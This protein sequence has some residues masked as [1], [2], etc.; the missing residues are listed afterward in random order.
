MNGTSSADTNKN[1]QFQQPQI[2]TPQK[3]TQQVTTPSATN[4]A[5]PVINSDN[6]YERQY[7]C[8]R[9]GFFTNNPRAVLYHRKE[10]HFEKIN[11]HECS[12][13]QYASQYSGK[14]ERH[15]LL[16]HKI[17]IN[18]SPTKKLM[19]SKLKSD[20]ASTNSTNQTSSALDITLNM[21]TIGDE[22]KQ[23]LNIAKF[24]CN[25]CP[26]KYKRS[27]DLYKH[28]KL[29]HGILAQRL[30]DY[31]TQENSDDLKNQQEDDQD[32]NEDI[33]NETN[34][35]DENKQINE[36]KINSYECPYCTYYS[37]GNDAEYLLHVKDHLCGKSF[38]C[39]L[40]NSVY[41]YRGDCVVHLK[42]K[43]QKS[44]LYAQN[45]VERFNLDAIDISQV[46]V[47]LKPKQQIQLQHQ[48][49]LQ[50]NK[51]QH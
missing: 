4:L 44:D 31:L 11:V 1:Q 21:S 16:R 2:P 7:T 25:K 23:D 47:L 36:N 13:C 8:K 5:V 49:Q 14:V 22:S 50:Q 15:T 24:Q 46:C 38:R 27:N 26:C 42:R 12:Y 39:V 9:C 28:L 6:H 32:L 40:C 17:D 20:F 48:I 29:K 35:T 34:C 30:S 3:R 10:F 19:N 51:Q 37:N 33:F 45:Y 18:N 43:H 41:K